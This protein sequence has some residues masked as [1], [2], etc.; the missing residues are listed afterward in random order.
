[1][2]GELGGHNIRPRN[3]TSPVRFGVE[4]AS[5]GTL[6]HVSDYLQQSLPLP[7]AP[8]LAGI[9]LSPIHGGKLLPAAFLVAFG[10]SFAAAFFVAAFFAISTIPSEGMLW[11]KLPDRCLIA[12]I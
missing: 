3:R 6:A 2:P 1:M 10:L 9:S 11:A 5:L 4:P 7:L 12:S 8:F